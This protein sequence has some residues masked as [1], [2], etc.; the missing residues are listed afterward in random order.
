MKSFIAIALAALSAD[1]ITL[2]SDIAIDTGADHYIGCYFTD[3]SN[4]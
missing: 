2:K 3:A 4:Q 1:A